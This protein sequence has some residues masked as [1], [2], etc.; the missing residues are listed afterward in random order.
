[1]EE[2]ARQGCWGVFVEL[3]LQYPPKKGGFF[4]ASDTIG[5]FGLC[6]PSNNPNKQNKPLYI[7]VGKMCARPS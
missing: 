6:R 1:M 7:G 2:Y 5:T 4:I 3:F